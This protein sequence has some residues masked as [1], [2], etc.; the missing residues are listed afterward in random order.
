MPS[1]EEILASL[2]RDKR[3]GRV[4]AEAFTEIP[5][6]I[7]AEVSR[8]EATVREA[9]RLTA[10][11]IR[12]V[13]PDCYGDAL[14]GLHLIADHEITAQEMAT[15]YRYALARDGIRTW[16]DLA[17]CDEIRLLDIRMFGSTCLAAVVEAAVWR[18]AVIALDG[19]GRFPDPPPE[20]VAPPEWIALPLRALVAWAVVERGVTT[21]D[22]LLSLSPRL[23]P[24]PAGITSQWRQANEMN[25]RA[26]VG[27]AA[28]TPPD[29]GA[30]LRSLLSEVDGRRETILIRRTF[31]PRPETY[32]S[33]GR[34]LGVSA[35]RVRQLEESALS[36]LGYAAETSRYTA[37]RRY[38]DD[39]LR[40]AP[41]CSAVRLSDPDPVLAKL[42][43]WLHD[44][45]ADAHACV[46][47]RRPC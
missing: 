37:L 5:E 27:A 42:L 41:S 30:L 14:P 38:L 18:M 24:L 34:R 19:S 23:G 47:P 33:L 2:L 40:D 15:R 13:Y 22:E 36:R 16:G 20:P 7:P 1:A 8:D 31:A 28:P 26:F 43:G 11:M 39:R 29:L 12:R 3:A 17:S 21:L 45:H 6:G 10:Q 44:T 9:V 25:L 46:P 35:G 32:Q 4:L